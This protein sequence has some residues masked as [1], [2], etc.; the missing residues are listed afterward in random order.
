MQERLL[1]VAATPSEMNCLVPGAVQEKGL[2]KH[3]Y[4]DHVQLLVTGVGIHATAFHLG[5]VLSLYPF[6]LAVNIG[7]AGSFREDILPGDVVEVLTDEFGDLGAEDHDEYLDIFQL[8]LAEKCEFP[9]TEG[10]LYPLPT[11]LPTSGLRKVR[12]S[13]V[14]TVHGTDHS[15]RQFKKRSSAEIE[16][17]EGAAFFYACNSLH[18]PSVQIRAISNRVEARNRKAWKIHEAMESLKTTLARLWPE[19]TS[20]SS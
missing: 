2:I 14:N 1:F 13:T 4:L 7:L 16:S 10:R 18:V 11:Q 8:K 19:I 17:M 3:P 12:A 15:I 9:F 5:R 6:D 20:R